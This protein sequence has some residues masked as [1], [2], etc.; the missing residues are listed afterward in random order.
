MR[1]TT[2]KPILDML[3]GV[4]LFSACTSSELR[5]IANLGTQI[6]VADGTQLTKEGR[7]GME[8]FLVLG[9]EA[10]CSVGGEPVRTM[11][12]G[13]FFGEMSLLDR[14]PRSATVVAS[15]ETTVLAF[16]ASEFDGLRKS[17]TSIDRKVRDAAVERDRAR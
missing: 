15:G 3:R 14:Q 13:E 16:D 12:P 9:G 8:F 11:G 1:D 4:P 7:P 5:S 2:P 17:S 6:T 10:R